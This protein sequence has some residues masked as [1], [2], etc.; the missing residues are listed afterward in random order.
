MHLSHQWVIRALSAAVVV[1]GVGPV[2]AAE[3]AKLLPGDSDL[4]LTLHVRQI[5]KDH[6]DSQGI[7]DYLDRERLAALKQAL[8]VDP[9]QDID[10]IVCAFRTSG[11]ELLIV[12]EGNFHQDRLRTAVRK[13]AGD[14]VGSFKIDKVGELERWQ[15]ANSAGGIH[16]LLLDSRT[17]AI[18]NSKK[19]LDDVLA[20]ATGRKQGGLT[21]RMRALVDRPS[22]HHVNLV[23]RRADRF[24]LEALRLLQKGNP[25]AAKT[26]DAFGKWIAGQIPGLQ[27]YARGLATANLGVIVGDRSLRLELDLST[28]NPMLAQQLRQ[29]LTQG[30]FWGALVLKAA[31]HALLRQ[32]ADVIAKER[33]LAKGAQLT[34][35]VEVPYQFLEEALKASW[36]AN[37]LPRAP[38]AKDA[39]LSPTDPGRQLMESLTRRITSIP[40]WGPHNPPPR[41]ALEVVAVPDL[42]YRTD[43]QADPFRH[44]LD[45]FYP[46]GKKA[47]PVVVLVHG[48]G[49]MLG[50][51][52]CCGL[53]SSVGRFLASQ[54][55]G[56][57]LPNYRLSPWVKHPEHV[58]DVARAVAW[59]RKHIGKYGGDPERLYLL[60]HS[61][62]GHLVSLLATDDTYLRAEG[63]KR[64]DI[65]GV[66]SASG[67]YRVPP[68]PMRLTLGGSGPKGAGV[69]QQW[70]PRGDSL[71]SLDF[72]L[73]RLTVTVDIAEAAFG[74]DP[75]ERAKASPMT[76]VRPGLPPFLL[77]TAARDLPTLSE[78]A[79][80]FHRALL[81]EGCSSRL[82][83][84]DKRNHNSLMFSA[85]HPEDP[86]ARAMLAFIKSK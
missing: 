28:S 58:K 69:D 8:G 33:V 30:N 80:E 84:L 59:T 7:R 61:A 83:K 67:V 72:L 86:A 62:G 76:Y 18:S 35:Q 32:L 63:L 22:K 34:V 49:W 47:F 81:R 60:G 46:K 43:P 55:I 40:L 2:T 54:G 27:R 68:G 10:R 57:V 38:G 1:L 70:P 31:D 79:E 71:V 25:G 85:I 11:N 36:L 21:A 48:G 12:A 52:R 29:L 45:F 64:S 19:A 56:V 73:P 13:L 53:Y 50:D 15:V 16:L 44:R 66:I 24:A 75:K 3:T 42:A 5:L 82:L 14:Q 39:R 20:R 26:Q 74:P 37:L 78:S 6:K 23:A 41:D 17:L 51:N 77:L 4:I 65:K 9:T